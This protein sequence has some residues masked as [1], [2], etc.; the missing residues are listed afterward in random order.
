MDFFWRE[1]ALVTV[2]CWKFPIIVF[3]PTKYIIFLLGLLVP[4][5]VDM[6]IVGCVA[7]QCDIGHVSLSHYLS[8]LPRFC[9]QPQNGLAGNIISSI[10]ENL[11]KL[12][13][14]GLQYLPIQYNRICYT[15]AV[16]PRTCRPERGWGTVAVCGQAARQQCS[17]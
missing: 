2:G 6:L 7:K 16:R 11:R 17:N 10:C 12:T 13:N 3:L 4:T 15:T 9:D 5:S 14:R 8:H 1:C